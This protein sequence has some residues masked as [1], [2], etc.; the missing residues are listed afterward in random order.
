MHCFAPLR[1]Q[2]F[3]QIFG[4]ISD[5][6]QCKSSKTVFIHQLRRFL[7][8]FDQNLS[9][10]YETRSSNEISRNYFVSDSSGNFSTKLVTSPRFVT[11]EVSV[12][13]KKSAARPRTPATPPHCS[14]ATRASRDY[15]RARVCAFLS[16]I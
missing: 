6:F 12:T 15:A 13:S 11:S 1:S 14:R 7:K 10:F 5:E 2:Q 16:L 9:E 3:S 4:N 8:I